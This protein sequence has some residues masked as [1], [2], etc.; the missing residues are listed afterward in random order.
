M[1]GLK[2]GSDYMIEVAAFN[3]VGRGEFSLIEA[4]T[5]SYPSVARNV[6]ANSKNGRI[7][8]QW[9]RP[10]NTGSSPVKEYRIEGKHGAADWREIGKTQ[11]LKFEHTRL[12]NGDRWRYRVVAVNNEG[13]GKASSVVATR[14]GL[15]NS[16][17][18]KLKSVKA[19]KV[20]G[21]K[22]KA[23]AHIM[24]SWKRAGAN[25]TPITRY[26]VQFSLNGK[27]WKNLAKT[28][29]L[30]VK[31]LKGKKGKVVHFRVRAVNKNGAGKWSKVTK[32]K[33]K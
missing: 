26:D 24:V 7:V 18:V 12:V 4:K 15:P 30:K 11:A 20:K 17:K 2:A 19:K 33:K 25:G 13:V 14:V 16:P 23:K 8:L 27:K 1:R 22:K 21:K 3:V 31:S 5:A 9:Q 29:K 10:V 6:R 32:I 28:K